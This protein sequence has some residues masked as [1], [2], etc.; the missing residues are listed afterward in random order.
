MVFPI[1]VMLHDVIHILVSAAGAVYQNGASS[2]FPC[3]LH[4]IRDSVGAFQSGND[5]LVTGK[6]EEGVHGFLVCGGDIVNAADVVQIGVFRPYGRIIQAAGYGM[7]RSR[8]AEIGRASCRER[9]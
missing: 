4:G 6:F 1:A 2:V 9:V 7:D 8:I 5:P 3:P